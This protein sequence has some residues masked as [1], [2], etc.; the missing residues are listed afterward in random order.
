MFGDHGN[1]RAIRVISGESGRK[2]AHGKH[3]KSQKGGERQNRCGALNHADCLSASTTAEDQGSVRNGHPSSTSAS[4]VAPRLRQSKN[5]RRASHD[6][7]VSP[8]YGAGHK[9]ARSRHLRSES[10]SLP[11]TPAPSSKPRGRFSPRVDRRES[12]LQP[13]GAKEVGNVAKQA[14]LRAGRGGAAIR[15]DLYQ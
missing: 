12:H 6:R 15:A 3:E 11:R 14:L 10:Q 1:I 2:S 7:Q 8:D 9:S 4:G 13:V 5:P